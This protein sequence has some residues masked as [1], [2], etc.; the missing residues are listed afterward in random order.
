MNVSVDPASL[1]LAPLRRRPGLPLMWRI[2]FSLVLRESRTRYG[3]TSFGYLWALLEPAAFIV[4]FSV[5]RSI[6]VEYPPFGESL[7]LF[8]A[9][10]LLT[11]RMFSMVSNRMTASISSNRN[12]FSYPIVKISDVMIARAI[13]EAATILAVM[14]VAGF[15]I[16][17]IEDVR[18]VHYPDRAMAGLA[19]TIALG[20]GIGSLNA[21]LAGLFPSWERIYHIM[22]LPLFITSG[23]FFVP[24]QMPPVVMDFL[25]W[26]PVLH[27]IEWVRTGVYLDYSPV[28]DRGYVLWLAFGTLAAG[29]TLERLTRYKLL[30]K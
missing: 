14:L 10:G 27:C 20:F 11:Y 30:Q 29:F 16:G 25:V 3:R 26:H 21:V 4:F 8:F 1:A 6:K 13:L 17:L 7:I 15:I 2:I 24:S 12:L 22:T 19:A 18:I 9:V 23:A 5:V 28:L